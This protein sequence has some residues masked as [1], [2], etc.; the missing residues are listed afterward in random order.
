MIKD[1][2]IYIFTLLIIILLFT[3]FYIW[4]KN[5]DIQKA[6]KWYYKLNVETNIKDSSWSN[7]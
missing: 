6:V 1:Y 3:A 5:K 2:K 4:Y 7:F